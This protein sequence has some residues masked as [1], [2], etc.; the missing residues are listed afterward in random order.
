MHWRHTVYAESEWRLA[1]DDKK[2]ESEG[3]SA[4]A[5]ALQRLFE[6]SDLMKP[7]CQV[8]AHVRDIVQDLK[9]KV[10]AVDLQMKGV[11]AN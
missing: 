3:F 2:R 10:K 4:A 6:D 7:R 8:A 1:A 5:E 9:Q 11:E